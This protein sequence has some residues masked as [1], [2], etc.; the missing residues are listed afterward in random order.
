MDKD[1]TN[2][3]INAALKGNWPEAVL[4]NQELLATKPHDI[5]T[6][7]RLAKAYTETGDCD[8]AEAMYQRVLTI[9]RFNQIALKNL[10]Q[11]SHHRQNTC[12]K[13]LQT[14]LNFIEEPG[15]T[16]TL[17]LT[18]LGEPKILCRL[19]PGQIVSMI[20]KNHTISIT[21]ESQEHIGTLTDDVAYALK[22]HLELGNKYIATIK[23]ASPS[24]VTIFIREIFRDASLN[25]SPTFS[26]NLI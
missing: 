11:M 5:P 21:T 2:K 3:A 9:D 19:I 4:L 23:S 22:R 25:D 24:K 14:N 18:K 10:K 16:K 1:L 17:P 6:L 8:Q 26:H 15:K 12:G 20:I 13:P 7:N